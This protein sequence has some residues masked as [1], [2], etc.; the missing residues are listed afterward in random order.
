[1]FYSWHLFR[2]GHGKA[3]TELVPRCHH[4]EKM[5]I[6]FFIHVTNDSLSLCTH[7]ES[8]NDLAKGRK[9]NFVS[10]CVAGRGREQSRRGQ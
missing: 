2:F 6:S 9:G 10:V 3:H 4:M 1:M 5:A 8:M 7:I